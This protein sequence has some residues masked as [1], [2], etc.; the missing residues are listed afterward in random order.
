MRRKPYQLNL[1]KF[2]K[3]EL[4]LMSVIVKMDFY[5]DPDTKS[6]NYLEYREGEEITQLEKFEDILPLAK[7]KGLKLVEVLTNQESDFAHIACVSLHLGMILGESDFFVSDA[8]K[9]GVNLA[10]FAPKLAY[11]RL[12]FMTHEI[13]DFVPT[14]TEYTMNL[15][16]LSYSRKVIAESER[17]PDDFYT[18]P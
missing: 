13:L 16:V 2:G 11:N 9:Y 7:Q 3:G 1:I 15:D 18:Y 17:L 4:A 10:E 6:E 14:L 5:G 8:E 12:T